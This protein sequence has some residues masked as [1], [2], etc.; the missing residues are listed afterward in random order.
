MKRII[1]TM[2]GI[3]LLLLLGC[4]S[5]APAEATLATTVEDVAGIWHRTEQRWVTTYGQ[6]SGD[7]YIQFKEDGTF[8]FAMMAPD[9]VE[10]D[11]K[12]EAEFWVEG[13]Q[14]HYR[15]TAERQVSEDPRLCIDRFP[16]AIYQVQLLENG[17]LKFVQVEHDGCD[18][19]RDLLTYGG[20]EWEPV[21]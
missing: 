21:R 9:R 4:A 7:S 2:I 15:L 3:G 8:G 16:T 20:T 6:F 19:R 11:P 12:V 14:L 1:A 5:R 18:W 17:N 13:T 10:D